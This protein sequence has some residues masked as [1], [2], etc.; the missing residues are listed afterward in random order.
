MPKHRQILGLWFRNVE[1]EG[2][3][4]VRRRAD[5]G[6]SDLALPHPPRHPPGL[7]GVLH[8]QEGTRTC[9]RWNLWVRSNQNFLIRRICAPD[10]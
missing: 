3:F 8:V 2:G 5:Q 9:G 6:V 7:R 1:L 10:C 4:S